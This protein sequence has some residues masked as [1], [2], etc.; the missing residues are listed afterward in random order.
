MPV[1]TGMLGH[2]FYNKHSAPQMAA[3]DY[4]LPW[5]DGTAS[6]MPL[7]EQP[8][9]IGLADF[10]CSEGRNLILVMKRLV[11]AYRACTTRPIQ[12]VHSDLST[13]DFSELFT[14]LNARENNRFSAT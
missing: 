8:P 14:G 6:A 9:T 10:G 5:V 2:G 11:A 12:T 13:N 7:N 4:V 1:I 3:V